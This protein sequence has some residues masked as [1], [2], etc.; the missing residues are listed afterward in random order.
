MNWDEPY[1]AIDVDSPRFDHEYDL[2]AA[3]EYAETCIADPD[4]DIPF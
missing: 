4:D 2:Y 3:L 1:S